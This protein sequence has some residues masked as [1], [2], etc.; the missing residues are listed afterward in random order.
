[1]SVSNLSSSRPDSAAPDSGAEPQTLRQFTQAVLRDLR[2]LEQMIADGMIESGVRRIGAEQELVLVDRAWRPAPKGPEI[3]EALDD[4]RFTTELGR[5]NL[6][7]NLDPLVFGGDC[8]SRLERTLDE[9]LAKVRAVAARHDV[10]VVLTG[11][12]P[13]L[14]QTDLDLANMTPA[15]RYRALNAGLKS[16]R[17]SSFELRLRG[18]D[19]INIKHDSVMLEACNTSCQFHLQVAPAEFARVYNIAQVV[20]APILAAACNSPLLFG[21]RLWRETRIAVFEQSIDT[22]RPAH[23]TQDRSARVSFGDRWVRDSILEIYQDDITRF[24]AFMPAPL[25]EDPFADLAANRIPKLRALSLH[26]GT[27]YRWNRPCYGIY[28]G[29]AQLR[30]ENRVLPAGPTVRDEIANAAFW[31]GL[32]TGLATEH[33]DITRAIEFD[34]A[35]ANLIAAARRGLDAQLTWL[36]GQT[37]AAPTLIQEELLPLARRGLR[38]AG[39]AECDTERYLDVV[40]QR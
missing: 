3:L 28:Q 15:P 30:I 27:V 9:A 19:E 24:R 1:M 25:D 12:L 21:K 14:Q 29:C 31:Y 18:T 2:A 37:Y 38:T 4:T 23:H 10:E 35:K 16:A 39:L 20:V 8:L 36:G 13:T 17:G 7:V 6:E 5:F 22:R 40:E 33:D 11:I 26:N 32:L 34:A